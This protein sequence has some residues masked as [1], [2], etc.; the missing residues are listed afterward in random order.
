LRTPGLILFPGGH[1]QPAD[2]RWLV[3][4]AAFTG[5]NAWNGLAGLGLGSG[6]VLGEVACIGRGCCVGQ[7]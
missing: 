5:R 7:L 3:G 6:C 2:G 1:V 4:L